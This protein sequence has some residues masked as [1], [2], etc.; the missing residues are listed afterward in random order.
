MRMRT[1]P[2]PPACAHMTACMFGVTVT[3]VTQ[4]KILDKSTNCP[5]M[6]GNKSN[7]SNEKRLAGEFRQG[8]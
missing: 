6:T 2:R 1:R 5:V 8:A 4:R 3:V 7:K